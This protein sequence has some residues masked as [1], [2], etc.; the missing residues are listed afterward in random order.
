MKTIETK[1]L[2]TESIYTFNLFTFVSSKN[3]G[4]ANILLYFWNI[5]YLRGLADKH[6][7]SLPGLKYLFALRYRTNN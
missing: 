7:D 2:N 3:C 6:A 5:N 1:L 4:N